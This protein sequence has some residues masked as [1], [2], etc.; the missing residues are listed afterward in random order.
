MRDIK[1]LEIIQEALTDYIKSGFQK[2]KYKRLESKVLD[3]NMKKSKERFKEFDFNIKND[4]SASIIL[5]IT[6]FYRGDKKKI[7]I[8]LN[9]IDANGIMLH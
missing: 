6:Y 2:R 9:Y 3:F 7:R 8:T 5:I 4:N 1:K